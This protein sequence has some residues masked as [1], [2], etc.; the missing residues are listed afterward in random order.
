MTYRLPIAALLLV[1]SCHADAAEPDPVFDFAALTAPPLNARTLKSTPKDG[2]VT[3]EVMFHSEKDGAKSVD[4]F[5]YF[6]Y[7]KGGKKLPAFVWN[8]PG[9]YQANTYWP[10]FGAR[11]GYATLCIDFPIPGYRS[12]GGYPINSGL[13]LG[14]DPRKAPIYHGAVALL[15]TVS[16]LQS[17][18]EVDP[19]R[20]GMAGSSW[21]GFYTTLMVGLDPRLKVGA[22][23]YGS[24]GLHLGNSWWDGNGRDSKRDAAFRARWRTTLDP[25]HRLANVKMPIAWLTG[26]NDFAYWMPA[27]M[28]SHARAAGPKHLTLLPNWNH[29]MTP[30]LDEQAFVWLDAHLKGKPAFLEVTPLEVIRDGRSAV[31]WTFRGPRKVVSAELILSAGDAGCWA[32]RCWQ[33]VP[34]AIRGDACTAAL[35]AS[36]LPYFVSGTV[37]DSD[38]FR[39]S[40]PLVR[41][42]PATLGLGDPKA[43]PGCDGAAEWGGFEEQQVD[44][45]L[46]LHG[47]P[48]PP[49]SKDAREGKQSAIIKMGTSLPPLLFT[50]GAVHRFTCQ[51]KADKPVEVKLQLAGRFDGKP[52][53]HEVKAT[54]GPRWTEIATE[55]LPPAALSAT[56]SPVCV[57]PAGVTLLVDDVHFRPVRPGNP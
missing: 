20:I 26:T 46:R 21:G 18:P 32:S 2:I 57:L 1:F 56:L 23:M 9:L 35:P 12:T 36:A 50:P 28:E 47:L 25:A 5:A 39:Y 17:R 31:R 33:T 45:Y 3:E 48:V 44:G 8:Q 53:L 11:R 43:L 49:L 51:V 54:A 29:A 7:P 4:I 15:K 19:D 14:D 55:F 42:D 38:G 6:S 52:L 34:A 40:T 27:V 10:E 37:I 13:E 41:I 16:Y 22:C 30:T 24:G